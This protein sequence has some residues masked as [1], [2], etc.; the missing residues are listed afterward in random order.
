MVYAASFVQAMNELIDPMLTIEAPGPRWGSA[1]RQTRN[2][3]VTF[4]SMTFSHS[5]SVVVSTPGPCGE[6]DAGVVRDDVDPAGRGDDPGDEVIDGPRRPEVHDPRVR[7]PPGD[8]LDL[9]ARRLKVF[10]R[11]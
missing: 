11:L 2:M 5:A 8:G 6:L 3:P 7:P 9:V 4:T 10:G 1:A